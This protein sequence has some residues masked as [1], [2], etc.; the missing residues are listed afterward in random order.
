MTRYRVVWPMV[1]GI[2]TGSSAAGN[3]NAMRAA[4]AYDGEFL[5]GD[6]LPEEIERLLADGAIK[7]V[8]LVDE[9]A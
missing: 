7:P 8:E 5:P 6:V 4:H 3:T 2:R 9:A 1:S